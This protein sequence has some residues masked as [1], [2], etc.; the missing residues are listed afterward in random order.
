MIEKKVLVFVFEC[1]FVQV[2]ANWAFKE[3]P[4]I[5]P[6]FFLSNSNI[7]MNFKTFSF[8]FFRLSSHFVFWT[9]SL[10]CSN[11]L[12]AAFTKALH[13]LLKLV[14]SACIKQYFFGGG[15]GWRICSNTIYAFQIVCEI[16]ETPTS[17]VLCILFKNQLVTLS[18]QDVV[19]ILSFDVAQF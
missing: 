12:F 8:L 9:I 6:L 14:F 13:A 3:I 16:L 1:Y 18:L 17:R 7:S 19:H 2:K 11:T 10:C 5:L 4:Y 15:E